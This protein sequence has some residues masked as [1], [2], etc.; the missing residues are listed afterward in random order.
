MRIEV[1]GEIRETELDL[2]GGDASGSDPELGGG[3]RSIDPGIGS[4]A[5]FGT[6]NVHAMYH[7]KTLRLPCRGVADRERSP[8]MGF[9]RP[10][11]S[12]GAGCLRFRPS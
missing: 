6:V 7:H 2:D 3:V 11:R 4:A 8:V 5:T 12:W 1:P 10:T 9:T